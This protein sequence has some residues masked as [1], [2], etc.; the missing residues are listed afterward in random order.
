VF[1]GDFW[2]HWCFH[3]CFSSSRFLTVASPC[4]SSHFS[5]WDSHILVVIIPLTVFFLS[6]SSSNIGWSDLLDSF[7][8]PCHSLSCFNHHIMTIIK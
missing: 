8:S 4:S 6:L 1:D 2:V 5:S 7:L 3:S